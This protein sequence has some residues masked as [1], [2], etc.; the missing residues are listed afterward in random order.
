MQHRISLAGI[1]PPIPTPFKENGDVDYDHLGSNLEKW[2]SEPLSGY[3]LG[4]SNGEYAYLTEDERVECVRVAR[5]TIPRNRLLIAGSAMESTRATINLTQRM[6]TAGADI[7]IVVTP[8]YYKARMTAAAMEHHY[9]QVA[10]ASPIPTMLYNVPANTAYELPAQAAINL[11]AHPNIIGMKE[12]GGDVTK[13]G[14][15]VSETRGIDFQIVAG[16]AGFLLAALSVGAVGGVV[17]LANIA[18]RKLAQM[19]EAFHKNDLTQAREIQLP[20][21]DANYAITSRFNVPGLKAAMDMLGYY[22]GPVRSPML[23]LT[24][25]EKAALRKTLVKAGIMK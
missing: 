2:N 10:D 18:S 22:G 6:A 19:V 9:K 7:A 20:L 3:V 15:M 12:S 17:A 8:N 4:G 14:F 25:D 13:V 11:A 24:D 21:I 23:P 1:F 5:Q 16:S